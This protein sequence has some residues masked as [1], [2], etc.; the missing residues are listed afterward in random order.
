MKTNT[1]YCHNLWCQYYGKVGVS[2]CL[3]FHD[4]HDGAARLRC[5]HCGSL[6]GVRAGTA[7]AGI[8]TDEHTY[9]TASVYWR[10]GGRRF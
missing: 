9:Q 7:Y 1:C 2:G 5:A 4:W 3:V 8:R 10:W 6:V